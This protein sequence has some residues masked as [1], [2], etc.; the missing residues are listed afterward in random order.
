MN[1]VEDFLLNMLKDE[2][3]PNDD[4][5]VLLDTIHYKLIKYICHK[6]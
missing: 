4:W 2:S 3:N 1:W 6:Y 5:C